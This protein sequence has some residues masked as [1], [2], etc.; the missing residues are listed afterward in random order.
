MR[1]PSRNVYLWILSSAVCL[2]AGA[3]VSAPT[4]QNVRGQAAFRTRPLL[5]PSGH[6][7]GLQYQAALRARAS[8]LRQQALAVT[9]PAVINWTEIGPGNVGG[10][11]NCI[12]V[13]PA[14]SQHLLAGSASGGLWQSNDGGTTWSDVSEFP[15]SLTIGAVAQLPNGTL[16]VGTGDVLSFFNFDSAG[17]G[18]G[19]FSSSDGGATWAPIAATAPQSSSDFWSDVN[20]IAVSSSGIV[21]AATQGGIARSADGGQTW[22]TVLTSS[23]TGFSAG[24]S[25]AV[26]FDPNNP[27]DA[28]ADNES[29]G[30]LYSTDGGQT[31]TAGTGLPGTGNRVSLA[32]DPSVAGSVY[33]LVNNNGNTIP[34]GEVFHSSNG[35]ASWTLLAGTS[36]FVNLDTGAASGALCDNYNGSTECQG[37]Y[38]NVILVEPHAS[39]TSPTIL[40]GGIDIY[41]SADGGSTWTETGSWVPG[42]TN[43]IH[44]DQ[45]AFNYS[46]ATGTL[47]VG[48]DGGFYKQLTQNSWQVQN[49]GLADTQFYSA[50]GHLGTTS[51]LNVVNGV[52]VTPIVAG[53]QDNGTQL[54]EGYASGAAPQP[55]DWI[56]IFG[57]DGGMTQVDPADGN[58]VYGEYVYLQM[59]ASATGGPNAQYIANEPPC[60]TAP[61]YTCNA[62]S[63][64]VL[65]PNG[66]SPATAMVAGAAQVWLLTTANPTWTSISA[67]GMPAQSGNFVSTI[68]IDPSNVNNVWVGYNDGE[69]WNSTNALS[70]TPTWIPSGSGT[71][72]GAQVTSIWVVPG[73]SNTVYATFD[74]YPSGSGGNVWVTN[75]GGTTWQAIGSGLPAA[76][77]Y[78][79]VTHPA[80][81]QIL[82]AGTATGVY[83]SVDGGRSWY[84]SSVGPAN[85][86]V[87]QLTWFD[88]SSPNNPTLLA[89]TFGRG[90]W[91]GS[92]AY[93]PTPALTSI[94]PSSVIVGAPATS[95]TLTGTG[96]VQGLTTAT[97]DGN[98]V[99]VSY[100]SAT[101]LQMTAP[102]AVL[103][104]TGTHTF[105]LSN[106]IPGGGTSA[107]AN[108]SV[109][110]PVPV[111]SSI[112]PT[113]AQAG[114]GSMMIAVTGSAFVQGSTVDWNGSPLSTTYGSATSLTATVPASD[115]SSAGTAQVTVVSAPPGGG[116]SS[117]AS[118]K[119]NARSSGGGALGGLTLLLLLTLNLGAWRRRMIPRS[120]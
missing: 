72:P 3:A 31:W 28:V 47:Y 29:G 85:V 91:L 120:Q 68:A 30:V 9:T 110:N 63:P 59:I 106:P 5:E 103:A 7:A 66:T 53:A 81:P 49:E 2:T 34:S 57:G 78:S 1:T 54:Y 99:A 61:T 77:V 83:S 51:S 23:N 112:S 58:D 67:S 25:L 80:Y 44:A 105:V 43:Y 74:N 100:Q 64:F 45:H 87:Q 11:L 65:V 17:G 19:M 75:D 41:T 84:T 76:P 27:N 10:R 102:A 95:V 89:A 20:A 69:L 4:L 55:D 42:D 104:V 71:L 46:A 111:L 35:G 6:Y 40:T 101:Q 107:A 15:G 70:A 14:N 33:G 109:V 48:N 24:F 116:T 16:L 82:Y 90:A 86:E 13:D 32:F 79:L 18:D 108:L 50:T 73:Q 39:G 21:L 94:S 93:N 60:D 88:T 114:S 96:F 113:S 52:P 36:A 37:Q 26:A 8:M 38:D 97:L 92:P 115:L 56:S 12:W 98:P 118:F 119:I 117:S 62:I 22:S